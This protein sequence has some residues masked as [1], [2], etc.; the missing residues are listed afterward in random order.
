MVAFMLE[1]QENKAKKF[2][3]FQLIQDMWRMVYVVNK[4]SKK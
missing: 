1:M 3:Y 2:E 4:Q